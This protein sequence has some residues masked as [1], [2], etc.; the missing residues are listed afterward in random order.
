V[1]DFGFVTLQAASSTGRLSEIPFAD[2]RYLLIGLI[3]PG[4]ILC[5]PCKSFSQQSLF[6]M[7]F[8]SVGYTLW[9]ITT[10]YQRYVIPIELMLGL[11]IL[12]CIIRL[13]ENHWSKL[14]V[15]LLF[16]IISFYSMK[17]PDWG[18]IKKSKYDHNPFQIDIPDGIK[19]TPARYIVVGC[20]IS[21]ILPYLAKDSL[22]YGDAFASRNHLV[23]QKI[24]DESFDGSENDP[25]YKV[26]AFRTDDGKLSGE[27][28]SNVNTI[29]IYNIPLDES[30]HFWKDLIQI[31]LF[32]SEIISS[33]IVIIEEAVFDVYSDS[34]TF[35]D[36]DIKLVSL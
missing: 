20:P 19:N 33:E 23:I 16:S 26:W 7:I 6:I 12:I 11:V 2:I 35:N 32:L 15:M 13:C 25:D 27:L 3:L 18:H 36:Y 22:F 24:K 30:E 4:A 8:V 28:S 31:K 29:S 9:A 34:H 5:R 1:Y 21:Y 14:F 10:A 17:V